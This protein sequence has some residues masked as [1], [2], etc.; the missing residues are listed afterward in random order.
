MLFFTITLALESAVGAQT[1]LLDFLS[2]FLR[3]AIRL[4]PLLLLSVF[5][6]EALKLKLGEER[7][8][9]LLLGRR[10]FEGRLRAALLGALLPFCECG[11]FPI[12]IGLLK[13]GVPIKV[14][15]TFFLMSP[16]I[17]LPALM[18]I[19]GLFGLRLALAYLLI[20]LL[21]GLLGSFLLERGG[22]RWGVFRE[23]FS[24]KREGSS[25]C[26]ESSACDST[27][28]CCGS[29][30]EKEKESGL[31]KLFSLAW[32]EA[33][34]TLIKILPLSILAISIASL[35]HSYVPTELIERILTIASPYDVPLA[36][37]GGIP[38]YTGDCSMV[39]LV[40]PLIQ[41]TQAIGPGIAFIIAGA[42]TSINGLVFMHAIFCKRFL[43]LYLLVILLIAIVTGSLLGLL[44]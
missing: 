12:M 13:A 15:L 36:A 20:T 27:S 28:A 18:I 30:P 6:A 29:I 26:G 7:L 35:L 22:V 32:Q 2:F 21:C 9:T 3:L 23:G 41:A 33:W 10:S 14:T 42:G 44:A 17:S 25:A 43:A 34:D 37:L 31:F 19:M 38:I 4:I 24:L 39:M 8:C 11:A 40:A 5:L 16:I 1:Q